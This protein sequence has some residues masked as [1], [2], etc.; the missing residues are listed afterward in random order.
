MA[1][2]NGLVTK[3]D[4]E[5]IK[6]TYDNGEIVTYPLGLQFGRWAEKHITQN[7]DTKLSLGDKVS[8]DDVISYNTH[9]FKPDNLNPKEVTMVSNVLARTV[10]WESEDTLEDSSAMSM[11]LCSRLGTHTAKTRV[12]LAKD[13]QEIIN[14]VKVGDTVEADSILCTIHNPIGDAATA[15]DEDALRSLEEVA[16]SNPKAEYKGIVSKIEAVYSSDIDEMSKSLQEICTASDTALYR[17]QRKFGKPGIDGKVDIAHRVNG[18]ALGVG[19]IAITI[20]ITDIN[21]MGV[22][23][24]ATVSNQLKTEVV[25]TYAN[26]DVLDAN[27]ESIDLIFGYQSISDRIVRSAELMGTTNTLLVEVT[28]RVVAAYNSE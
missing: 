3:I 7:L 1:L 27:G 5:S 4:K 17:R 12:I 23:D 2:D 9:F 18:R 28:K 22:G 11:D 14:L 21:G 24:K 20:Y 10:L 13:T 26:E 25:R 6:V 15:F 16:S 19:T 8:K